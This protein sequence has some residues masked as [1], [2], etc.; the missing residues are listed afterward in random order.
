MLALNISKKILFAPVWVSRNTSLK[1]LP[2][3]NWITKYKKASKMRGGCG[4]ASKSQKENPVTR[5][6]WPR[7]KMD[8][9]H[10]AF[11]SVLPPTSIR[12]QY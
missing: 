11:T 8:I 7:D 3:C 9:L 4:E 6:F 12:P 5:Y 2:L 10:F 1:P